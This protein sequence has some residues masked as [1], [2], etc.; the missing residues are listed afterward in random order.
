[1]QSLLLYIF[2]FEHKSCISVGIQFLKTGI[3]CY[4][5]GYMDG[6]LI[7]GNAC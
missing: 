6:C 1:M 4:I 3:H 2:I 5:L 7:I